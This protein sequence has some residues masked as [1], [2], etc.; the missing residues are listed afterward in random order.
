MGRKPS[1]PDHMLNYLSFIQLRL[2]SENLNDICYNTFQECHT[3]KIRDW[4]GM[5]LIFIG[6][7]ISGI[8]TSFFYSFGVPYIDD[9][10]SRKNSPMAIS[11]VLAGRTLGPA[12]GYVLGTA[13]LKVYVVPG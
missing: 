2:D 6:F 9:N 10:V 4:G 3:E 11:V 7:F 5:A 13:T 1:I 12:L 8:G